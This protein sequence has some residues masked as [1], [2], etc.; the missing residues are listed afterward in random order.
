MPPLCNAPSIFIPIQPVP[1]VV[2][3]CTYGD[4]LVIHAYSASGPVAGS[5]ETYAPADGRLVKL[6]LG[7]PS[8]PDNPCNVILRNPDPLCIK[9]MFDDSY[10][11]AGNIVVLL[12]SSPT[13]AV[14][15]GTIIGNT[16]L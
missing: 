8:V 11:V 10:P 16:S 13:I 7:V 3:F 2:T 14:S 1:N 12:N 5:N 9:N 4:L 15:A 6:S